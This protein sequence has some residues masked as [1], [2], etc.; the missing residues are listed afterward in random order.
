[1]SVDSVDQNNGFSIFSLALLSENLLETWLNRMSKSFI[2]TWEWGNTGFYPYLSILLPGNIP[3]AQTHLPTPCFESTPDKPDF[4]IFL[5]PCLS[6]SSLTRFLW[7]IH[8]PLL[9]DN[10][11]ANI[12][13]I[14]NFIY[15]CS[16]LQDV[17]VWN[18]VLNARGFTFFQVLG[19][20]TIKEV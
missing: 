12:S 2:I 13:V 5:K 1:M 17:K 6:F 4:Y 9:L 3:L 16:R 7:A 14:W 19:L 18:H 20:K 11:I 15:V 10:T 8:L